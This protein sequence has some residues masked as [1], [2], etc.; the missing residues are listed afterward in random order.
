V[1]K[2]NQFISGLTG[3]N[4]ITTPKKVLSVTKYILG[5][6]LLKN[7]GD[8][9]IRGGRGSLFSRQELQTREPLLAGKYYYQ[10][11]IICC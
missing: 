3:N 1:D 4:P 5:V 9:K 2:Q 10:I 7:I 8:K 11:S 6:W